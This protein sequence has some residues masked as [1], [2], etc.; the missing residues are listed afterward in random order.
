MSIPTPQQVSLSSPFQT[1]P[2]QT[3]EFPQM[4]QPQ[5]LQPQPLQPQ[6]YQQQPQP[7]P[8]SYQ[9][10]QLYQ[11]PTTLQ[12]PLGQTTE[13]TKGWTFVNILLLII[14]L[15][16]CIFSIVNFA[17]GDILGGCCFVSSLLIFYWL[18]SYYNMNETTPIPKLPT[19]FGNININLR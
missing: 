16:S 12:L 18:Y 19:S 11:P 5:P 6:L 14:L 17:Q 4:I 2:I 8:F 9:Q 15:C 3:S 10:P 13:Q 1:S 7:Q